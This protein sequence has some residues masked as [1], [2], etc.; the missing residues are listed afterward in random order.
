MPTNLSPLRTP[1]KTGVRPSRSPATSPARPRTTSRILS[2][3]STWGI[4]VSFSTVR[5]YH[6]VEPE[7]RG[8][9]TSTG[10]FQSGLPQPLRRLASVVGFTTLRSRRLALR[11]DT[12]PT[13][14]PPQA[15]HDAASCAA[16]PGGPRSR[17][18]SP[19]LRC[20]RILST[21]VG[22]MMKATIRISPWQRGHTS[23]SN[24]YT[25]L[26]ISAQ[27]RR[28]ARASGVRSS[29]V[30]P[31]P[32]EARDGPPQPDPNEPNSQGEADATIL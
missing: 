16:H 18:S 26:I 4:G 15:G 2:S 25:L 9:I 32:A 29:S 21:T 5:T 27:R 14:A 12:R 24:S 30:F 19:A 6:V 22:L 11:T 3:L 31:D 20:L 23:G 10:G 8:F 13:P 7:K 1:M 17:G 28:S